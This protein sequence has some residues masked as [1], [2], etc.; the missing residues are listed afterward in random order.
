VRD[1]KL[2]ESSGHGGYAFGPF[3]VDLVKRTL[4]REGRLVPISQ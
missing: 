4:S 1:T 2:E 3:V